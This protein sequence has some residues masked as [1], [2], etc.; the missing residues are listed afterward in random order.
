MQGKREPADPEGFTL[1]EITVSLVV[2]A[3]LLGGAFSLVFHSQLLSVDQTQRSV[4]D[5]AGWRVM[6]RLGDEL[7]VAKRE[8]V[9]L[10]TNLGAN[11][12]EFQRAAG[13]VNGAVQLGATITLAFQL[14]TGEQLNNLDD[15]GDGRVDEGFVT[16]TE[17]GE[18]PVAIA[19]NVLR[20]SFN[21]TANGLSFSADVG[22]IDRSGE[23]LTKTFTQEIS[24]RN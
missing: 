21:P 13:Y 10:P 4:I 17:S 11:S 3:M 8:T 2:L 9:T 5:Q 24:Y 19:G 20:L 16:Y 7:Q 6:D 18:A 22:L 15:N 23:L 12:V 1:V 14:A